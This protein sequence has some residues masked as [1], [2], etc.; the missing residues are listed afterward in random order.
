[1]KK[2]STTIFPYVLTFC[3]I[4]QLKNKRVEFRS[5]DGNQVRLNDITTKRKLKPTT[6]SK[7]LASS[8]GK[9]HNDNIR[10]AR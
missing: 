9:R 2:G 7:V 4:Q 10:N 5:V 6:K 1:M 8:Q 3:F